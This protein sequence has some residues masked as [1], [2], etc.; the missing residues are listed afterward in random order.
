MENTGF[1]PLLRLEVSLFS[2]SGQ[3]VLLL[4]HF[5]PVIFSGFRIVPA[6]LTAVFFR[7]CCSI[8]MRGLTLI[9]TGMLTVL[10]DLTQTP[11]PVHIFL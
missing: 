3:A 6:L 11:H 8:T 4:E 1:N 10:H 7:I 9:A 2:G 5:A